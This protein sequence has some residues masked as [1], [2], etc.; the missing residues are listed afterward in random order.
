LKS[1]KSESGSSLESS[2]PDSL[3]SSFYLERLNTLTMERMLITQRKLYKDK[4]AITRR[5]SIVD[6]EF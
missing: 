1:D 5:M 2:S 4:D 3:G 6:D